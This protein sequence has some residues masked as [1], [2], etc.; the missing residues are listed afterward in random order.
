MS[1]CSYST[2]VVT[3]TPQ[4]IEEWNKIKYKKVILVDKKYGFDDEVV[5]EKPKECEEFAWLLFA[6]DQDQP[7]KR[8]FNDFDFI[9]FLN[10]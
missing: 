9:K 5:I 6:P 1:S 2:E 7:W 10:E 3:L 4:I 8:T